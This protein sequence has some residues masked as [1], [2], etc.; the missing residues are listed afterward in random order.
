MAYGVKEILK[1]TRIIVP[2]LIMFLSFWPAYAQTG[3]SKIGVVDGEKLFDQ[4]PGAQDATK[5]ISDAQDELRNAITETEKIYAEFEKQKKSEAEK[6]TKKKELQVK[7]DAKAQETK[8]LI[9][10]LSVKIEDEILAAIKK[11]ASEKGLDVVFDKRAVLVGGTDITD[12]VSEAL[13]KKPP[14]AEKKE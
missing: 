5:K 13:K 3:S 11:T 4:Y 8:T 7:I 10:S 1:M 2:V 14:I 9:E 6:L 12:A